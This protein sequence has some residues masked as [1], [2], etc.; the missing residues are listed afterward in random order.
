MV[1]S[2][3]QT[4]GSNHTDSSQPPAWRCCPA[5]AQEPRHTLGTSPPPRGPTAEL[6]LR[7]PDVFQPT[8]PL[9]PTSL[10]PAWVWVRVGSGGRNRGSRGERQGRSGREAL[11]PGALHAR[12]DHRPL[13]CGAQAL[14]TTCSSRSLPL[15]WAEAP[16]GAGG[17]GPLPSPS[18]L[19]KAGQLAWNMQSQGRG[20]GG[21]CEQ[22]S[23]RSPLW[24]ATGSLTRG[25]WG[26]SGPYRLTWHPFP[27]L[28]LPPQ[29]PLTPLPRSYFPCF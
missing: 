6:P 29:S 16:F 11:P 13:L 22:G 5:S 28:P 25:P 15:P 19:R 4:R 24:T 21:G 23:R 8:C 10:E 3:A 12:A 27:R 2:T 14:A 17:G 18:D 1:P 26:T 9:P 20:A 7:S